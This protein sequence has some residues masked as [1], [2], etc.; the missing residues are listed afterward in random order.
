[1]ATINA[2][3]SRWQQLGVILRLGIEIATGRIDIGMRLGW[4]DCSSTSVAGEP[5]PPILLPSPFRPSPSVCF[6]GAVWQMS[7][8]FVQ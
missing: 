5:F 1:M 6:L 8:G 4:F 3:R 7:A 2:V